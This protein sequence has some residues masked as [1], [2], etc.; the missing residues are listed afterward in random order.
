MN[1]KIKKNQPWG[2]VPLNEEAMA[3]SLQVVLFQNKLLPFSIQ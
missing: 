2:L 1:K 3:L